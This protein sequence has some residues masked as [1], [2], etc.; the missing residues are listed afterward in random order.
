MTD[1][2]NRLSQRLLG[3]I[4]AAVLALGLS[5]TIAAGPAT[6][7][8]SN[9]TVVPAAGQT[10]LS[11][12]AGIA[13]K[14]LASSS[15]YSRDQF[16]TAWTD[17]QDAPGG[18]NGCDTRDDVLRRDLTDQSLDTDGC[19]VESGHLDD[20]YAGKSIDFTRGV[21]TSSAVQIDHMVALSDA[22]QTGAQNLTKAVRTELGNDPLNLWA[23]DGPTN[24]AKGDGDASEW[25]PPKTSS[26]CIYVARQVAVKLQYHLWVTQAEHD[27]IQSTLSDGCSTLALPTEADWAVPAPAS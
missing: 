4:G 17:N 24:D 8:T 23:V 5:T 21:G 7:A 10:A 25:L 18:H 3:S 15:G 14:P 2:Q 16:G 1:T 26:D 13:I 20:P 19:T 27:A 6:A 11:A 9:A 12:L 22:W